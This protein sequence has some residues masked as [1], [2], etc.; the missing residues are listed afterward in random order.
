MRVRTP[1]ELMD[2]VYYLIENYNAKLH[3]DKLKELAQYTITMT[4][5]QFAKLIGKSRMYHHLPPNKKKHLQEL[6][7][8]DTQLGMVVKDYYQDDAFCRDDDGSINMWKLYNLFTGANKSSYI[9]TF[10]NKGLNA[11]SFINS[12]KTAHA[13]QESNWF[14]N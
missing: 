5:N 6:N 1:E 2:A 4:E 9:D 12:I 11:F 13:N 7:F 3:L 10:L 8:G 14:L